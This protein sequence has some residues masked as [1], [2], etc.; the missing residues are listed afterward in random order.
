QLKAHV[1][2]STSLM[3]SD[4]L[5]LVAADSLY[6]EATAPESLLPY[7]KNAQTAEVTLDALPGK[8]LSGVIREVIA[9]AG[10]NNRSLRLRIAVPKPKEMGVVV[11]GFARATIQGR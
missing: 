6:F 8:A 11:G 9:V 2:E 5:T 3:R 1:G 7:L 10:D 4:L